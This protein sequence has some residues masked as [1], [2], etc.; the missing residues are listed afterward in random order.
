[1]GPVV[2]AGAGGRGPTMSAWHQRP[3]VRRRDLRVGLRLLAVP[4]PGG[5]PERPG[6]RRVRV[7]ETRCQGCNAVPR[8]CHW[9]PWNTEW[10]DHGSGACPGSGDHRTLTGGDPSHHAVRQQSRRGPARAPE[11][12][13]PPDA[14]SEDGTAAP[15]SSCTATHSSRTCG[16]GTTNSG[17]RRSPG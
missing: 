15:A 13:A 16:E 4:L 17:S 3:L 7:E 11:G 9:R 10:G 2:H 5:R 14:G 8:R 1:M 12:Q 6:H